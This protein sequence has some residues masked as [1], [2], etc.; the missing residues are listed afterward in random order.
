M[1]A[2]MVVSPY[3]CDFIGIMPLAFLLSWVVLVGLFLNNYKTS[4][5]LYIFIAYVL[6]GIILHG[7]AV[8]RTTVRLTGEAETYSAVVY[9]RPAFGSRNIS[10]DIIVQT[11][12]LEGKKVRVF[13]P[14]KC[15]SDTESKKI[16]GGT[17]K[18]GDGVE[19]TSMFRV[20]CSSS[21]SK[22]DYA[23]YLRGRNIVAVTYVTPENIKRLETYIDNISFLDEMM[24]YFGHWRQELFEAYSDNDISG[25]E[26]AVVMAMTL[27]DKS[28]LSSDT[29]DVYSVSGA[30]H[31]LALSGL[32]LGIIYALFSF[33]FFRKNRLYE[34]LS[35]CFIW[36]Y[37][38]LVGFSPSVVRAAIMISICSLGVVAGRESMSLNSLAFAALIM[39][40]VNPL[41]I[42]DAGFQLSFMAVGF[43]IT[44]GR[45]AIEWFTPKFRM[46]HRLFVSVWSFAVITV[47]AQLATAP[48]VAYYFGG[49]PLYF[50][51]TNIVAIPFA[52]IILYLSAGFLIIPFA[53]HIFAAA[54]MYVATL[55][56][57]ILGTIASFPCSYI[58]VGDISVLQTVLVYIIIVCFLVAVD[59]MA[60]KFICTDVP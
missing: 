31:V 57:E 29:K 1:A 52:S 34:I 23:A 12:T 58:P 14:E 50:M 10:F 42:G 48:L 43:I 33:L 22:F 4:Q 2:G 46:Q 27:G 17:L 21:N 49:I 35:V 15:L 11:G 24:L 26:G 47:A 60:R 5:T 53:R 40:V 28:F 7:I 37:V 20:P 25:Q 41:N 9:S 55:M 30:S 18:I 6:S 45:Q 38:F 16:T 13:I 32:H 44:F 19:L 3:V 8:R 51:L 54:I 36:G 59:I 56:N 39:L